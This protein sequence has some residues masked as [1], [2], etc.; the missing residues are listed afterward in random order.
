MRKQ[1]VTKEMMEEGFKL[2]DVAAPLPNQTYINPETLESVLKTEFKEGSKKN[3]FSNVLL[4]QINDNPERKSAPPSFNVDVSEDITTNVKKSVQMMNP[5]IKNTDKQLYGDLWQNFLLDDA[6]RVF[7]STA[8][9]RVEPGDQASFGK[10][11]YGNMPSSKGSDFAS[12]VQREKDA[13]RY[14]LY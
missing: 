8:N 10:Y 1:K 5:D 13:Y 14:T 11:L 4:T 7:Y 12:A 6:N 3:P 2:Q 9:T